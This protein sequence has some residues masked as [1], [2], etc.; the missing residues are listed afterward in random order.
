VGFDDITLQTVS[1]A[2]SDHVLATLRSQAYVSTD[3]AVPRLFS[4]LLNRIVEFNKPTGAGFQG[5]VYAY[6]RA[7]APHL[8]LDADKVRAGGKRGGRLGDIDGWEGRRRVLAVEAKGYHIGDDDVRQFGH[9]ANEIAKSNT[10]GVIVARSFSEVARTTLGAQGL[11]LVDLDE[12][13]KIV[14]IWD[15]MKETVAIKSFEFY[16]YRIEKKTNLQEQLTRFY[17]NPTNAPAVSV[18]RKRYSK[19]L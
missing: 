5:A 6:Y 18:I 11:K 4:M 19:I 14:G 3:E 1:D 7:D 12:L 13:T 9:F 17:A 16:L 15:H 8:F 2:V 10:L